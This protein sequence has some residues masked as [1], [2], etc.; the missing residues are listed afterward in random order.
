MVEACWALDTCD[1]LWCLLAQWYQFCNAQTLNVFWNC[2]SPCQSVD[3]YKNQIWK[4]YGLRIYTT[5]SDI[6]WHSL[7]QCVFSMFAGWWENMLNCSA[8]LLFSFQE[9]SSPSAPSDVLWEP[10]RSAVTQWNPGFFQR[11]D[12]LMPWKRQQKDPWAKW[13]SASKANSAFLVKPSGW[14]LIFTLTWLGK[15]LL[16]HKWKAAYEKQTKQHNN[17]PLLQ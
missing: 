4:T 16:T 14:S 8:R 1:V 13:L 10:R 11:R 6:V 7:T 2:T 17:T 3:K 9:K 12:L 15:D 5:K